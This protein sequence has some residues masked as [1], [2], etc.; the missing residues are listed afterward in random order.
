MK[1]LRKCIRN[2]SGETLRGDL[3]AAPGNSSLVI[4][5]HG[6]GKTWNKN[7]PQYRNICLAFQAAGINAFRFSFSGLKPSG[8]KAEDSSYSKQKSDLAAVIDYFSMKLRPGPITIT[9]HSFGSV[10]SALQAAEDSRIG[11]L[12]LVAPRL[13]PRQSMVARSI[14]TFCGQKLEEIVASPARRF[15]VGPIMIG[16]IEYSFSRTYIEDLIHTDV[17]AAIEKIRVPVSILRG[18]N[19]KR[20][21]EREILAAVARNSLVT[22]VPLPDAGHSF[23]SA[24]QREALCKALVQAYRQNRRLA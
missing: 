8:G 22:Y 16:D 19:D 9:A 23:G 10:A 17:L 4:V 11:Q 24:G 6:F 18:V 7:R 21:S 13:L 2:A 20:I 15:P 1:V 5:C 12:L 14:E 3:H